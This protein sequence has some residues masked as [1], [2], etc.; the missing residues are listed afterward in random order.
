MTRTHFLTRVL[1]AMISYFLLGITQA[2]A[3]VFNVRDFGAVGDDKTDNT[4]AFTKCLEALIAAGGGRMVLADGVYRGRIIIPL[5]TTPEL[6]H[7][8]NCR[9]E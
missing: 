9:R 4:A 1:I 5:K 7:R 6:D 8:G 2:Q 3:G